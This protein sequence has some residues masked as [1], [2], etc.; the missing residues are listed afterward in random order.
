MN[1]SFSN[2]RATLKAFLLT[3]MSVLAIGAGELKA[4]V[5]S[6]KNHEQSV[7]AGWTSTTYKDNPLSGIA[8]GY[9][10]HFGLSSN[11]RLGLIGNL[12]LFQARTADRYL[13]YTY[14]IHYGLGAD[15]LF[16]PGKTRSHRIGLGLGASLN[17]IRFEKQSAETVFSH[18]S[19]R[20]SFEWSIK[21][22]LSI[23]PSATYYF[24]PTHTQTNGDFLLGVSLGFDHL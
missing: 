24:Y 21:P 13:P 17:S 7:F 16:S 5:K 23:A 10:Y 1:F 11:F 19:T 15:Y 2:V 9:G 6:A 8:L 22:G 12:C 18:I 14:A 20:Y 4:Q 3:G